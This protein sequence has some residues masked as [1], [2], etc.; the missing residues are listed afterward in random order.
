VGLRR[1][2]GLIEDFLDAFRDVENFVP[3][4]REVRSN[5]PGDGPFQDPGIDLDI[6]TAVADLGVA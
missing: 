3:V 6:E 2:H 1:T 4:E 5:R